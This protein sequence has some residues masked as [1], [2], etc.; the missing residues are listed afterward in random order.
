MRE[1]GVR[2]DDYVAKYY[3]LNKFKYQ[4]LEKDA[5]GNPIVDG[6]NAHNKMSYCKTCKFLRPPR[7]F[8]CS[9]CEVCVEIHDHHC[10]WV[11]NCVG[12]RNIKYFIGFLLWTGLLALCTAIICL[13]ALF[14]CAH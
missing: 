4:H 13:I 14:V 6:Q 8:H 7:S 2:E 11:G 12:Y 5:E 3:H 1:L 9:Q 10:P